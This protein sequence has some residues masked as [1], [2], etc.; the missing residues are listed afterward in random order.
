[1]VYSQAECDAELI[2]VAEQTLARIWATPLTTN[3]TDDEKMCYFEGIYDGLADD[4]SFEYQKCYFGTD[5]REQFSCISIDTKARYSANIL[6]GLYLSVDRLLIS[7]IEGL[8]DRDLNY[9]LCEEPKFEPSCDEIVTDILV[10]VIDEDVKTDVE[11]LLDWAIENICPKE[12][13]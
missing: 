2:E 1:M 8:F 5:D 13:V 6:A 10:D 11:I 4:L 3:D 12:P 9:R 7:D